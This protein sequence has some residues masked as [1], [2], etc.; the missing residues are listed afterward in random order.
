MRELVCCYLAVTS[1]FWKTW[2]FFIHA[3]LYIC[4]YCTSF[5][6]L[7]IH[8]SIQLW[9]SR[10]EEKMKLHVSFSEKK[11]IRVETMDWDCPNSLWIFR[12]WVTSHG[13]HATPASREHKFLCTRKKVH[14]GTSSLFFL[15]RKMACYLK[16]QFQEVKS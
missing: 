7:K 12:D 2:P 5:T 8:L 6:L 13:L 11:I 4:I 16:A 3:Y 14:K 10:I 9:N 15:L 1:T